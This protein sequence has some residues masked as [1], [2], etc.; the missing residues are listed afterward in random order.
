MNM[1]NN[2]RNTMKKK[3]RQRQRRR[4]KK[5]IEKNFACAVIIQEYSS[6]S[7]RRINIFSYKR[8][9]KV[10]IVSHYL[11]VTY[12]DGYVYVV[13]HTNKAKAEKWCVW[14]FL[15]LFSLKWSLL[16]PVK[17][18]M[19]MTLYIAITVYAF[20]FTSK[21]THTLTML[22]RDVCAYWYH[23]EH[24]VRCVAMQLVGVSK[25][26]IAEVRCAS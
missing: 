14:F 1:F 24:D 15:L 9:E 23:C 11:F 26:F 10:Q 2:Q 5:I 17:N 12:L 8:I 16:N 21:L 20:T 4:R 13:E 7:N 25:K 3:A 22:Q 19:N 6:S 18:I